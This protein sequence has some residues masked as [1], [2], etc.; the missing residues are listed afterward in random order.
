MQIGGFLG[1]IPCDTFVISESLQSHF[2]FVVLVSFHVLQKDFGAC[3]LQQM[4]FKSS[5]E[6]LPID[7]VLGLCCCGSLK[8]FVHGTICKKETLCKNEKKIDLLENSKTAS[9]EPNF[10]LYLK[11]FFFFLRLAALL[12]LSFNIEKVQ[13]KVGSKKKNF[14]FRKS[15]KFGSPCAVLE[16]P[17]TSIFFFHF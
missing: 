9:L 1:T 2:N 10:V 8:P 7:P 6:T 15:T 5:T 17:G 14:F 16:F 12:F 4:C 3:H 11:I 13:K